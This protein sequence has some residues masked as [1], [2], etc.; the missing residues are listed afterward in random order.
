[1]PDTKPT[2]TAAGRTLLEPIEQVVRE[3]YSYVRRLALTILDD[4]AEAEDAAQETFIAANRTHS[5]FRGDSSYRTWL[6]RI[7]V[8]HCRGR[9]RQ[10]RRRQA[11]LR[12]LGQVKLAAAADTSVE[13]AAAQQAADR[14]LWQA[15]DQLDE[16]HRLPLLLHYVQ[17]LPVPEIA[18]VLEIPAGTIYSRLFYARQKLQE[19]LG[20]PENR[21]EV[22]DGAL[23]R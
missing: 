2:M 11:L 16:K 19:V 23:A 4:A 21:E 12:L 18:Q 5:G 6:T 14:H 10:R 15:V 7:T 1:M 22:G 8:N 13:S 20:F 17:G 3:H 9:L